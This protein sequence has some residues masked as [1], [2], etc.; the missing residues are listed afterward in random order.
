MGTV[1]EALGCRK[2]SNG[3]RFS[4]RRTSEPASSG[5][6]IESFTVATS[7]CLRGYTLLFRHIIYINQDEKDAG[8]CGSVN[9]SLCLILHIL[10]KWRLACPLLYRDFVCLYELCL[11]FLLIKLKN[12]NGTATK[13]SFLRQYKKGNF[14][15]AG[16][17]NLK[18]WEIRCCILDD[19][20]TEYTIGDYANFSGSIVWV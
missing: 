5:L 11:E 19:A 16:G 7:L 4:Q 17:V 6:L 12:A 1:K 13:A 15:D 9:H 2:D 10:W 3:W 20:M 18:S 14:G 8:I